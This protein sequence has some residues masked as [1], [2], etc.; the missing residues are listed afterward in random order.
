MDTVRDFADFK[1]HGRKISIVTAYD[2]WS[3]RLI[4][5]SNVDAVLVGDSVAMVMHGYPSTLSATVELMA[6]HTEAV[7]R[8]GSGKFLIADMPFLSYRQGLTR[9]LDAVGVLMRAG[10]QAVK[11]EGV[12]GHE[13]VIRQI[14]GSGVPVMG[15]LGLTPQS[16]NQLG[17]YRVQGRSDAQA[18]SLRRQARTL[19]ELGCFSIVLECVTDR[20]AAEIT[21]AAAIPTIGIGAGSTTD[22]QV[23]VLQD[24]WG[25]NKE[26]APRFV[27]PY[28]D[29]DCLLKQAL[30]RYD[31]DV[32]DGHFPGPKET[33]S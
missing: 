31:A 9:A 2:F 6:V 29:G 3:A 26:A 28:A 16:V 7:A 11:L 4:G 12:D 10:A 22:G 24:L 1:A 8:A 23:L 19:E 17:G 15:H 30:D 18:E 13:D 20:L 5:R 14:V 21:A 25:I 33:Y 27:R 32:K